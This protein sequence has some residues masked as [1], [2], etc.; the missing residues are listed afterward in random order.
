M[1]L[2][3]V[4]AFLAIFQCLL[5]IPSHAQEMDIATEDTTRTLFNKSSFKT[6]GLYIAPEVQFGQL[7]GQFTTFRSGSAMLL[8]NQRLGLGVSAFGSDRGFTPTDLNASKLL[9]LSARGAGLK[10]EYSLQPHKMIHLSFP[11]SFGIGRASV[12]SVSYTRVADTIYDD[13]GRKHGQGRGDRFGRGNDASFGFI[14]PG[15]QLDLNV[16]K[17]G[18]IFLGANYRLVTNVS[19][20]TAAIANLT[21][22]QLGGVSFNAGIKLGIFNYRIRKA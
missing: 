12:D 21:S 18:K 16:F 10:V 8:V 11:L 6:L 22:A 1:K 13:H 7:A 20:N 4:S 2:T 15:I 17:Y 9:R 5:I 19:N 14:Q 3:Q